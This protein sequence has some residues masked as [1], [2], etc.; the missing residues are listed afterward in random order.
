MKGN[1]YFTHDN[2]DRPFM[3]IVTGKRKG[4]EKNIDI[5]KLREDFI[6]EDMP[7]K[8]DYTEFIKSYKNVKKIFIGKNLFGKDNTDFSKG[9]TILVRLEGN[10][11]LFIGAYIYKFETK[12]LI[13]EYYSPIFG[14]DV[15]YPMAIDSKNI[16]I[17]ISDGSY[18]YLPK[19]YIYDSAEEKYDWNS[20]RKYYIDFYENILKNRI[21]HTKKISKIK[22]IQERNQ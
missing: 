1:Y 13:K 17:L 19:N 2:G 11:Y 22:V 6:Y 9:N 8:N 5:Y 14:S 7:T 3:V 20:D 21:E 12:R 15:S 18:G 4:K 10:K 16:Y